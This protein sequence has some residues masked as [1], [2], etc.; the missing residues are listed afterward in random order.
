MDDG[1]S[2]PEMRERGDGAISTNR[3]RQATTGHNVRYVLIFGLGGV[4]VAF[5]VLYAFFFAGA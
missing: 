5:V 3:A 4:V 2:A 1:R